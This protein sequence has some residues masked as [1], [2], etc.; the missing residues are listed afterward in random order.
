MEVEYIDILPCDFQL[1]KNKSPRLIIYWDYRISPSLNQHQLDC[2]VE[3]LKTKKRISIQ[4]NPDR[5]LYWQYPGKPQIIIDRLTR[6]L[7]VSKGTLKEFGKKECMKQAATVLEILRKNGLA[8]FIQ[9]SV[10]FNPIRV[11]RTREQREQCFEAAH[12]LF[13]EFE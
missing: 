8:N 13:G 12:M 2:I 7:Y 4:N 3:K 9:R 10:T 1:R 6:K 5:F 11:G